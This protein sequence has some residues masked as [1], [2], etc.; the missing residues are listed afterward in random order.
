M[1]LEL[2]NLRKLAYSPTVNPLVAQ[3]QITIKR[4]HVS[5]GFRRDLTDVQTGEITH[6]ATIHAIEE[7]DD[8]QFVKVFAA[9]VRAIYELTKTGARAFQAIL[10]VY[11]AEPMAGGFADSVYLAWFDGG[12]AGRDLGMSEKTFQRGLK[13]LLAKDFIAPRT[14]NLFWVNPSLFFKGDRVLFLRE[15]RRRQTPDSLQDRRDRE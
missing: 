1:S 14:E 7:V 3:K 5:T 12:L 4:R 11:Q 9:G 15:Y 8:A 6:A 2:P 10:E 13:E